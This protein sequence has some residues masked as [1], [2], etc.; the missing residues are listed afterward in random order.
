MEKMGV[1]TAIKVLLIGAAVFLLAKQIRA[2]ELNA[3][4]DG[5]KFYWS[6]IKDGKGSCTVTRQNFSPDNPTIPQ[7][8]IKDSFE[9][10][11]E[12]PKI[13]CKKMNVSMT[14]NGQKAWPA[15]EESATE[16]YFD[17]Q[18]ITAGGGKTFVLRKP[19]Y[20][21]FG[22]TNEWDPRLM[23]TGSTRPGKDWE[24]ITFWDF[25]GKGNYAVIGKEKING[26][27]CYVLETTIEKDLEKNGGSVRRNWFN[28]D[29]DY[30]LVRSEIWFSVGKNQVIPKDQEWTKDAGKYLSSRTNIELKKYGKKLWGPKKYEWVQY[31][32]D[33]KTKTFCVLNKT[34]K[35]YDDACAYNLGLTENDLKI[36]IPSDATIYDASKYSEDYVKPKVSI[37]F[38]L[39]KNAPAPGFTETKASDSN[40][41]IYYVAN[42]T[43]ITDA[44]IKGVKV[45]FSMQGFPQIDILFTDEGAKKLAEVTGKHINERMAIF[46]NGKLNS[47]PIIKEKIPGSHLQLSGHFTEAEIRRIIGEETK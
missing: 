33:S 35:I 17:G 27:E 3:V 38:R 30:C 44:D 29:H 21:D 22:T 34:T 32:P 45:S 36:A 20:S 39:V 23:V 11:F 25:Q 41:D 42:K 10:M 43:E 13:R 5:C 1:K 16:I 31:A 12:G 6:N 4:K 24:P 18:K 28:I 15:R 8:E 7:S 26:D 9:W 14:I 2:D 19:D 46:V 40:Q 47:A 37:E